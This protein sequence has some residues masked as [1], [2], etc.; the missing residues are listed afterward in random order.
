MY[1]DIHSHQQTVERG[2]YRVHNVMVGRS[3]I[4]LPAS[5]PGEGMGYSFGV[6]PWDAEACLPSVLAELEGLLSRPEV[7]MV[8]ETGLDK[9]AGPPLGVQ[10]AAF[11]LQVELAASVKKPVILHTVKTASAIMACKKAN[12][13]VPAW[14][15][16]GFRGGPQEAVQWL[17]QGF[18]LSFGALFNSEALVVCPQDRFFLETDEMGAIVAQYERVARVLNRPVDQLV[19]DLEATFFGL[20]PTKKRVPF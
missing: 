17:S 12:P 9:M 15:V 4:T 2:V 5:I 18:Y 14:I 19:A 10:E 13:G 8:G 1:I 7:L 20:F 16:H 6:H 3:A 11:W